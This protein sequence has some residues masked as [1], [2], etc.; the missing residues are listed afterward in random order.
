[1]DGS[2]ATIQNGSSTL[3]TSIQ[4][5]FTGTSNIGIAGF[6]CTVDS[7]AFS[8]CSSPTTLSNLAAGKHTFQVRA[9][10]TSGNGDPTPASFSW[11]IATV[12][13]PTKTTITSAVDGNNAPVQNSG[14]T[15]SSSIKIAF[16]AMQGSNPIAGFQC[17]LDNSPFSSCSSPAVFNNLAAGP[18]KFTVVAVDTKGNKDQNPAIFSWTVGAV[19]P[20]QSIQQL[21][22]L[23]HS[24]HLSPAT[25]QTLDIRL[26]IALQFAQNNAKSGTCIQLTVFI[27]QVQAELRAG[28]VTSVQ[29]TQLV[30]AA[31][32]IQTGLGCTV[33]P[34]GIAPLL[35]S[36]SATSPLN[37][38]HS[39]QPQT[40][41]SSPSLLQPQ[42][43]SPYPYPNQYPYLSQNPQSQSPQNQ[44]LPPVAYAGISQTVNENTRVTLDGR[45]SYSPTGG[46]VVGY[47]LRLVLLR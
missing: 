20:T 38:T 6:E 41:T 46:V 18:H 1:V 36:A 8:P 28:H 9:V 15:S 13:P 12:T 16:T 19:P 34:S 14:T 2:G 17:S 44:Q 40:T 37:L 29:A 32:N 31:Q 4:F 11:T 25:D 33:T 45:A 42:S 47:H 23:K 35:L 5:A 30:Q 22:Q 43:Q 24:M 26:N 10:D 27:K 7:S 21:I 39:Q 3:S